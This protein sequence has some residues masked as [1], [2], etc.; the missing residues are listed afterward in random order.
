MLL[1]LVINAVTFLMNQLHSRA[2]QVRGYVLLDIKGTYPER[3]PA[4]RPLPV[5]LF[6]RQREEESIEALTER[7]GRIAGDPRVRGAVLRFGQLQVD[8]ASAHAL[9][10]AIGRFRSSGKRAIVHF[11]DDIDLR[12]Y[13]AASS[14]SEIVTA[15]SVHFV[16][17]GLSVQ[18]QFFKEALSR[19]GIR[20][21]MERMGEYKSAAET[22]TREDMSE[23]HRE[24]LDFLLDAML[25]DCL[26]GMATGRGL[27]PEDL[28]QVM[29]EAPFNAER[30]RHERLIDTVLYED[31]LPGH[32]G[33]RVTP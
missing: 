11:T 25:D 9:R 32:L 27:Q 8:L 31:E 6:L 24:M 16:A 5:R 22:F 12:G 2:G 7:L 15:E 19:W 26:Q 18:V 3:R 14:A 1:F 17:T 30:A 29:D 13:Y 33:D 20:A 10:E 23:P 28:R 21:D 4:P